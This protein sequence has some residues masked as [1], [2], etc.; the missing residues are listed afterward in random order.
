[1]DVLLVSARSKTRTPEPSV[2]AVRTLASTLMTA[3][4]TRVRWLCPWPPDAP[5]PDVPAGV[6]I[7]LVRSSAPPF[8][9]VTGQLVDLRTETRLVAALRDDPPDVVHVHGFGGA[10]SYLIAWTADRLGVATVVEATPREAVLCHRGTLVDWTG[11]PCEV[12]DD[13][14]RCR[15][16]TTAADRGALGPVGA[17]LAKLLRPLRG[18]SPFPSR[19]EF[20]NRLDMIA[21]GLTPVTR[22]F[23]ASEADTEAMKR[24][25]IPARSVLGSGH[26]LP[27]TPRVGWRST[28]KSS[29]NARDQSAARSTGACRTTTRSTASGRA[30]RRCACPSVRAGG[31]V[32]PP[33]EDRF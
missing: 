13:P 21:H 22:V 29:G 17:F 14:L 7:E 26:H 32:L 18:L 31:R 2:R 4:A 24:I 20:V 3:G 16:C 15:R 1:M 23:V 25:G 5:P 28:G 19:V 11:S 12:F 8:R 30:H 33:E 6:A 27:T 9:K 10:S